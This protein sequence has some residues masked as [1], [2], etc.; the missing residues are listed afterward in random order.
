M[1]DRLIEAA[2]ES[3][4]LRIALQAEIDPQKRAQLEERLLA[5]QTRRKS[6]FLENANP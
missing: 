6:I 1:E 4:K 5:A 2:T 3:L